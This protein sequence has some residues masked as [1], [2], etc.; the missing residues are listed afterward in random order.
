MI[1]MFYGYGMHLTQFTYMKISLE[2]ATYTI[3]NMFSRYD[4][5]YYSLLK[6]HEILNTPTLSPAHTHTHTHTQVRACA[7]THTHT[8]T[9]SLSY[10]HS[11]NDRTLFSRT[12]SGF[13]SRSRKIRLFLWARFQDG[14]IGVIE[15]LVYV[16]AQRGAK[17]IR[18]L[19]RKL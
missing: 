2:V 9:I 1:S 13:D 16:G 4:L 19:N 3:S 12:L 10:T 18:Q 15:I 17:F 5:E 6:G 14:G 11:Q 7:H 8:H